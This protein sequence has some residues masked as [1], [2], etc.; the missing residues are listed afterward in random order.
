M[1]VCMCV[2]ACVC[3]CVFV[4]VC[5]C[6]CVRVCMYVCVRVYVCVYMCMCVYVYVFRGGVSDIS[7]QN[8]VILGYT[9]AIRSDFLRSVIETWWTAELAR[10]MRNLAP[11]EWW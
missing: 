2:R 6:M 9:N 4:Y 10:L 8:Y 5:I 11:R 3:V 1:R 7:F